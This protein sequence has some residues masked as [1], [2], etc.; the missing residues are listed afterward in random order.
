MEVSKA[1]P[2]IQTF[3]QGVWRLNEARDQYRSKFKRLHKVE[4]HQ[5]KPKS[6]LANLNYEGGSCSE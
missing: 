6:M 2:K 4:I 3:A 1:R 5:D